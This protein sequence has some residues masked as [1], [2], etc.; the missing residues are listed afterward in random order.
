MFTVIDN[1][2]ACISSFGPFCSEGI[3]GKSKGIEDQLMQVGKEFSFDRKKKKKKVG[4]LLFV[5]FDEL[6]PWL[7]STQVVDH[8]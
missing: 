2:R 4:Q 1:L 7:S 3:E 5:M 6:K 8:L